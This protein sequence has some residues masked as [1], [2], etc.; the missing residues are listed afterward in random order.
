MATSKVKQP[1]TVRVKKSKAPM[2]DYNYEVDDKYSRPGSDPAS[3]HTV[4]DLVECLEKRE[5]V[6][7]DALVLGYDKKKKQYGFKRYDKKG[8]IEAFK[9]GSKQFKGSLK[10]AIDSFATDGD[11]SNRGNLIGSDFIP[12]L[13][14]N[15]YKNLYFYDYIKMANQCF[16]AS[17]HDPLARQ[18]INITRDFTLG[19]GFKVDSENQAALAVWEAFERVND[20]PGM[21]DQIAR[22]LPTYGETMLWWLPENQTKIFQRPYPG[23]T[24]S[25][26]MIP[27]VRLI[28]PSVIWE[29]V[30]WPE[31]VTKVLYYVWVA[32]T[33]WQTYT[34]LEGNNVPSTKFIFQ[35]IPA[36]QMMH[37]KIN[38]YVGEKRGRSD[39]FPILGFLKR[40]RDSIDY[41]VVAMQKQS[42]YA[43]DVTIKGAQADVDAYADAQDAQGPMP[44]AGSEF[45]HTDSVERKFLSPEGISRGASQ[46]FEWNL[47]MIAA[48]VGIPISYFGTHLSGG[49]TRA[50]AIVATEPVA[51][52]FEM[53]QQ[54]YERIIRSLWDRVMTWA[55]LGHVEMNV[56]FPQIIAQDRSTMMK[57]LALA[58]AQGWI[59]KE[60]AA[61]IAAKE[62]GVSD[63]DYDTEKVEIEKDAPE[64]EVSIDP[65]TGDPKLQQDSISA[66]TSDEKR[67][68]KK[69][70][71]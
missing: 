9:N 39:L 34:G 32:P 53:R 29:V 27:R 19:R 64:S 12:L 15:F 20:L 56:V 60:R 54:V 40:M 69:Q 16:W 8:F 50:S 33:A 21:M 6:A 66:V 37:F 14:G 5:D 23:Q 2:K 46:A 42:A 38:N 1:V 58:E 59:T 7:I 52:K 65:L 13:G 57:D 44:Q 22:E 26:G 45:I 68:I 63:F 61:T 35:T 36:E 67:T 18:I 25:K 3:I 71:V 41:Q 55:G 30:T 48:G 51:K 11:L 49:Q 62:L 24:V 43:I 31:D 47:S 17:H 70:N 4:R 28:D 10:E